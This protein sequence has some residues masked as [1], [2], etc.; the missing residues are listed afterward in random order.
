MRAWFSTAS[1]D[2]G[3]WGEAR[4]MPRSNS[5]SSQRHFLYS[6]FYP[7]LL[8]Q[9]TSSSVKFWNATTVPHVTDCT[10]DVQGVGSHPQVSSIL[11]IIRRGTARSG[12]APVIF[13]QSGKLRRDAKYS[14]Q[15]DRGFVMVSRSRP[16]PMC[17]SSGCLRVLLIRCIRF[18]AIFSVAP[19]MDSFPGSVPRLSRGLIG[20]SSLGKFG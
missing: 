11:A 15:A 6:S 7:T 16:L 13:R 18:H 12:P 3:A 8:A 19:R 17:L 20:A 1:L 4:E 2:I 10:P 5:R 9:S 14:T